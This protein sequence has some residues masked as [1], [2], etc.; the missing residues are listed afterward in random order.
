MPNP[1]L[2]EEIPY[3]DPIIAYQ[4]FCHFTHSHLLDPHGSDGFGCA[5]IAPSPYQIIRFAQGQVFVD[6][7]PVTADPFDVLQRALADHAIDDNGN[8]P[9][10]QGGAVGYFGYE[11]GAHLERLPDAGEDELGVPDMVFGLYDCVVSFDKRR[12]RA[13]IISTGAP[14][15]APFARSVRAAKRL[16]TLK[17]YLRRAVPYE[18]A[19]T[20]PGIVEWQ[21]NFSAKAYEAAV[22][23]CVDYIW[24]GDVFQ[25][26]LARRLRALRPP[27]LDPFEVYRRLSELSPAPYG[28][29]LRFPER[30]LLSNSPE[31]FLSARGGEV[32]TR[33]IKGTRPRG[34]LPVEDAKYAQDLLRSAKDRAENVMIVDLLRNDLSKV[35][36]PNSVEVT[37]LCALESYA[38]VHHLVSAVTGRLRPQ[39]RLTDLVKAGFPGGSIT[40]A[41]KIRAMEIICEVEQLRRGAYCGSIGY[42]GFNGALDLSIAIRTV[43]MTDRQISF[44]VGGGI[45]ADS[46]PQDEYLET[47]AK[48]AKIFEAFGP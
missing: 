36:A 22:R 17:A 15:T 38:N 33:P 44:H 47:E 13:W 21:S 25:V 27:G 28:A 18:G 35:C 32:E 39:A 20:A 8:L 45:V 23:H 16:N 7:T 10:F 6:D 11:L 3:I 31:R 2:A 4:P 40:G 1:I 5:V 48:A 41:P 43:T 14:E 29:Y 42:L 9:P 24:Q 37:R 46:D 26:N 34:G 19:P 12:R 30:A